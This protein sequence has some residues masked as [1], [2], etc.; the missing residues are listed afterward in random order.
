MR[1]EPVPDRCY[2]GA[3]VSKNTRRADA[4][5]PALSIPPGSTSRCMVIWWCR[6]LEVYL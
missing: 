6:W 4:S 2:G 3:Q 1:L 5:A